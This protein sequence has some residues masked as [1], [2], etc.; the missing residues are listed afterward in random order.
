MLS[1]FQTR[2]TFNKVTVKI[3]VDVDAGEA[4]VMVLEDR[5]ILGTW[6][7]SLKMRPTWRTPEGC[8]AWLREKMQV[9]GKDGTC[10]RLEMWGTYPNTTPGRVLKAA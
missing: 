2:N 7:E 5:R 3:T 10:G 9:P 4:S 6:D 1:F 8:E